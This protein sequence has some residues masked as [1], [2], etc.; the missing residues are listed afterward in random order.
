MN[1]PVFNGDNPKLWISHSEM[2]FDLFSIDTSMWAKVASM[3]F[4]I[5]AAR[6]LQSIEG[7]VKKASWPDLC[8]MILECLVKTS[9]LCSSVSCSDPY[10]ADE[11]RV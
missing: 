5:A 8:T 11:H 1:F 7:K 3:N 4:S 10:Q 2:Y 6:W 9:M